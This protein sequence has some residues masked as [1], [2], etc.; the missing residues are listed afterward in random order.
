MFRWEVDLHTRSS[1]SCDAAVDGYEPAADTIDEDRDPVTS[2]VPKA[3][4][5]CHEHNAAAYYQT[6]KHYFLNIYVDVN[7][8]HIAVEQLSVVTHDN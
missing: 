5:I 1:S 8:I 3:H 4:R 6:G 7:V 2:H